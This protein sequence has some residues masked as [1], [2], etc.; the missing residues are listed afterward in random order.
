[1][2]A[3]PSS[4]VIHLSFYSAGFTRRYQH[5]APPGLKQIQKIIFSLSKP[6]QSIQSF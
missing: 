4:L 6:S 2:M 1:M 5:Y 3:S